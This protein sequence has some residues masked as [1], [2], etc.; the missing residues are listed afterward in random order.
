MK[1]LTTKTLGEVYVNCC[2]CCCCCSFINCVDEVKD[3]LEIMFCKNFVKFIKL[4]R[5]VSFGLTQARKGEAVVGPGPLVQFTTCLLNNVTGC[6][7]INKFY[8]AT[9]T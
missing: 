9:V 5:K 6:C 1:T 2:C 7:V 8:V 4:F 3:V